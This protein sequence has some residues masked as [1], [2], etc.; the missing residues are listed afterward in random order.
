MPFISG[1]S[2]YC[3][4]T[5]YTLKNKTVEASTKIQ[6]FAPLE[7]RLVRIYTNVKCMTFSFTFK[8][9]LL[10]FTILIDGV[11]KNIRVE[12][13]RKKFTDKPRQSQVDR[14]TLKTAKCIYRHNLIYYLQNIRR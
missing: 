7:P 6:R 5:F 10:S 8:N 11:L 4:F 3:Q 13:C 2:L 12:M 9:A 1:S 14:K